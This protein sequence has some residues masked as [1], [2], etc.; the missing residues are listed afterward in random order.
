LGVTGERDEVFLLSSSLG[1]CKK[2]E[3]NLIYFPLSAMGKGAKLRA[4]YTNKRKDLT[5]GGKMPVPR[6]EM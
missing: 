4:E 1:K 3:M 2:E 6:G 5:L